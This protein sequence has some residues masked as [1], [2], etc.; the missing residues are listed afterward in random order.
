MPK[1]WASKEEENLYRKHLRHKLRLEFIKEYGNQCKYCGESGP[2]VL[3]IDHIFNDG[4]LER[5]DRYN[6]SGSKF[7]QYLKT[8]NW[9]KDRYQLL[10]HNCNY[11]KEY[12]RRQGKDL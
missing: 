4:S 3:T 10:C 1:K 12:F 11:R 2:I 9:P 7:Y 5:R 8:N 6:R